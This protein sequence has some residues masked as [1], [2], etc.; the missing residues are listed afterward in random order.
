MNMQTIL[1]ILIVDDEA[2]AREGLRAIIASS[3]GNVDVDECANGFEAVQR[4][5]DNKPD[6]VFLDVQMPQMSGLDVVGEI[7]VESMPTVV[8]VTAYAEHAVAAFDLHAIDYVLKPI[9]K[10]RVFHALERAK[11]EV[12]LREKDA[13][14][15]RLLAAVEEYGHL[16]RGTKEDVRKHIF[17]KSPGRVQRLSIDE[18]TWIEAAGNYVEIH[19]PAGT[20]LHRETLSN[21]ERMLSAE[22]FIRVSRSLIVRIEEVREFFA[23]GS[24][25]FDI[26]LND[27]TRLESGPTYHKNLEKLFSN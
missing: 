4:I 14:F 22:E 1:S 10:N 17:V 26:V 23:S 9:E 3:G 5:R 2:I 25:K 16:E 18:I 6:I 11:K 12:S 8:F 27:G 15:Q 24:G 19:C 20:F 7:G 13:Y 21:M